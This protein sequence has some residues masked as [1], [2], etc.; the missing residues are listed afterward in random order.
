MTIA[1]RAGRVLLLALAPVVFC[2]VPPLAQEE[3]AAVEARFPYDVTLTGVAD[4]ALAG[5]MRQ[6][7]AL[8]SLHDDPPPSRIGLERRID[9]DRERLAA[10]LRSQGYYEATI[11]FAIDA[12]ASPAKV[13]VAVTLGRHYQFGTVT[14]VAANGSAVPG[15]PYRGADIGLVPDAPALSQEV[16]AA[17]ARILDR[18]RTLGY[19]FAKVADRRVTINRDTVRMAV[20]WTIDPGPLV[21][22]GAV[23]VKGLRDADE[24]LIRNRLPWTPGDVFAPSLFDRARRDIAALE[25]FDLV[26]LE[27]DREPG[28]GGVT[29]IIVTVSERPKRYVGF[30]VGY[31]TTEGFTGNAY[32]G[33][34]N[35]FG[36]GE[37]LKVTAQTGRIGSDAGFALGK[38]DFSFT[39][40][41][42]KP[43]V[44]APRQDLVA[45]IGAATENPPAYQRQTATSTLGFERRFG[46]RWTTAA[47][48]AVERSR[49][50]TSDESYRTALF[51]LPVSL[52]YDDADDLLDPRSGWRAAG[53]LTPWFSGERDHARSF[54]V[55]TVDLSAY[56]PLSAKGT[57]FAGRLGLGSVVGANLGDIPH[58]KR[59]YAGGGGSVRGYGFQKVGPRNRSGDPTGGRSR[60]ELSLEARVPI[61][62]SIGIVPFIDAGGI[63]DRSFPDFSTPL[64]F[65]GGVGLRYHTGFGPLRLDIAV[66]VNR[67]SGD[68]LWQFYLS[69][70]QAF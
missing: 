3:P 56:L 46:E 50:Q 26:R 11:N 10:A 40:E 35:L 55:G 54:T 16:V 53:K 66:P 9:T 61:T 44:L 14:V 31:A 62:E 68:R 32:W 48:I 69:F 25:V 13:T 4:D 49:I 18:L 21:R 15:E 29:P 67:Q 57:V 59:L 36:G 2:A 51:G 12:S 37:R 20:N 65:A 70:G 47:G 60:L 42:R 30:S 1:R 64:R 43:D 23:Q 41:G 8:Y 34:R 5:T 17:E 45:T 6:V 27:L 33:H 63:Y 28:P 22:Y 58:D 39:V 19:A 7:S 52:R 24:S 38:T